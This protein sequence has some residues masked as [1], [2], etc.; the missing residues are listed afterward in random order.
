M[1]VMI[2]GGT[3][4]VG[5]HACR[6]LLAAGHSVVLLVRSEEK[7]RSL[8]GTVPEGSPE[9]VVGDIIQV[10]QMKVY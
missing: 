8:Y 4:F 5:S 7:A 1:K 9:L 3:G 6:Q 10:N 2:T